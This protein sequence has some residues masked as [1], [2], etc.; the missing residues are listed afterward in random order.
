MKACMS[1]L[2]IRFIAGLQYRSAAWAGIVT[3]F[4]WGFMLLA[5]Y[6]AFYESSSAPPPMSQAS[7]AAYVWL[8]QAFLSML[9]LW[10][11]DGELLSSIASGQVAYE[12]CRPV[13]LYGFWYARLLATRFANASLRALPILIIASFLPAPF[14]LYLPPDIGAFVLFLF[15]MVS[16]AMMAVAV[17]MFIYILTFITLSPLGSRQIIVVLAEFFSGFLIPLPLMPAW[18]QAIA[19]FLPFRYTFDLP[20]RIY[21]GNIQGAQALMQIGVQWTWIVGLVI[22][23]SWA[24]RRVLRR[25]VIQGG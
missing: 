5:L 17:S 11:Q 9:I 10:M 2:R 7:L 18:V 19:N 16:A 23:G 14:R 22:L 15:S 24:M 21:S 3:Q 8:Q 25:A 6:T 4:L 20:L 13:S 1:A 12:L